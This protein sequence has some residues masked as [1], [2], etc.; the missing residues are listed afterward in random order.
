MGVGPGE[1]GNEEKT[2]GEAEGGAALGRRD[3]E[4]DRG[5]AAG[6]EGRARTHRG[7]KT[8][9]CRSRGQTQERHRGRGEDGQTAKQDAG[10]P[11]PQQDNA[12]VKQGCS[13]VYPRWRP[14]TAANRCETSARRWD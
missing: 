9:A 5:I 3:I 6:R 13:R 11:K 10:E 14:K 1:G 4:E 8:S 2:E 7:R 12:A